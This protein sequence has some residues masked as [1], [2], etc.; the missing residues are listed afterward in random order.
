MNHII[1]NLASFLPEQ[2]AQGGM[3][4]FLLFFAGGCLLLSLLGYLLFGRKSWLN[5]AFSAAIGILFIYVVTVIVYTFNPAGLAK[6]LTPLPFVHF[7]GEQLQIFTYRNQAWSAISAEVVS[8][9]VLAFLV[10]I[11]TS[12]MPEGSGVIRWYV[13]RLLTVLLSMV[14]HYIA[15]WLIGLYLP[16][17]LVTYASLILLGLLAAALLLGLLKLILGLVLTVTNPIIGAIYSFFFANKIGKQLTKA[18]F[19][20]AMLCGVVYLLER[21]GTLTIPI[22]VSA[23]GSYIPL[24]AELLILWYLMGHII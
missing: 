15:C 14:L 8:M 17:V 9:I 18:L 5:Q 3:L 22:S 11:L 16:G 1:T 21:F 6:F 13:Y 4:R 20:T 24:I 7:S 2:L 23:L 10:N 19:S 12:F